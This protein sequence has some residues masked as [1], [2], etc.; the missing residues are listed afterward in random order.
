MFLMQ[1]TT[2]SQNLKTNLAV[3]A[4]LPFRIHFFALVA[5]AYYQTAFLSARA[6]GYALCVVSR[7]RV[8]RYGYLR[9]LRL[10]RFS[11]IR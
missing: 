9:L 11:Y 8:Y 4:H 10:C 6:R 3:W 1:F 2:K 7:D 5:I